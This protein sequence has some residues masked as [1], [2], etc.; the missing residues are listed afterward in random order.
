MKAS[1]SSPIV[2][3]PSKK[4]EQV[5][6]Y[7]GINVADPY[8]WL[9]DADS[10]ETKAWVEAQNKVTFGFLE[11]IPERARL[12]ERLTQLWNYEKF[13]VPFREGDR[14][15]FTRNDGLQNQSVLYVGRTPDDPQ[16]R[17]LLDP[18]T[19][20][21]DG[22]VALTGYAV[23]DDGQ[24]LAYGLAT[25]GSD[26]NEWRVR[27]VETGEDLPDRLQWVK[28]SGA[29]WTKDGKGFFY[30]RYDE[31]KEGNLLQ[32]T[33]Y[34]QKLYYHRV[35]TPQ[36][37]D[38][39]VYERRDHKEWGFGGYVTDDGRYLGIV[40]TMG[41]SP[42][43]LFFYKDL[44][45]PEAKVVELI[46][47]FIADF[48]P[49]GN[50][51]TTFYFRTDWEAPRGRLI[52]IDATRPERTNWREIIPQSRDTL[53]AVRWVGGRFVA[54]YLSDAKTQVR[55]FD[56]EGKPGPDIA[57][58]GIGTAAGFGGKPEATETFYAFTSFTQPTSIYRYDFTTGKSTLL[59]QPKVAFDPG[60]Y[61][62]QQVFYRSKDGTRIPM[63][64]V[65]RKGLRRD[66]KN[67][68][69]LYGYGGFNI[70]L[71]PSFSP[72]RIAWLEMGGVLA[73]P[74]L[75]G[76]GEY[77]EEWHQAGTKLKKQNV[78]DDF[79]AAAEWLIRE[80][81]T[82]PARL[83]I[84]GGSNGGLL[85]GACMTQRPELFGAALPAVG[86]LDMLRFNKFTIGW[87]WESDYG[88]PQNPE[89][90][91]ALYAYSPLHN[92][93]PGTRY[94]A[95]L[96]TTADHDDRVVPA[97]S[98]KFAAALQAAHKGDAPVLIRIETKA[99]HG[100]GK[101]TSK[102]IEETADVWAFLVR[103]F[104]MTVK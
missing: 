13:G 39:L 82:Q 47:D 34:Y 41:T 101:P 4:V 77:G 19:L 64:I 28:F 100:A 89:E 32:S 48:T 7:H 16:A 68:T 97:H 45:N 6:D 44:T 61:V 55:M 20:S 95:T 14:Y 60:A 38:E 86:V 66:G 54:L 31:P 99:G 22:T 58:P 1:A 51:G 2:Y 42:R 65:H 29:S 104:Q 36:S 91:R 78:F 21:S 83:A 87:A 73:I 102:L 27:N 25:A 33:N 56:R 80:K 57:L 74:N 67:P 10:P 30:S 40:V 103:T 37:A 3:P 8:R 76:G 53:E 81:Y 96:I 23:S 59:R 69:L 75:R 92:L 63:F 15:F 26:W 9:E 98:F 70:S 93:K 52:A 35:G 5:D 85:V 90:F 50:D 72:A 88:S 43:N 94:P 18:N 24:L 49:V 11:S 46:P 17:V 79:I 12:R 71:T 84:Q 62:T